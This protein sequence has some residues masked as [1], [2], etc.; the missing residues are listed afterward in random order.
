MPHIAIDTLQKHDDFVL[1]FFA[2][3]VASLLRDPT[4][5]QPAQVLWSSPQR[6]YVEYLTNKQLVPGGEGN[7]RFRLP[8]ISVQRMGSAFVSDRGEFNQ[9]RKICLD[10]NNKWVGSDFPTPVD[11][12]YQ[13][14]FLTYL[15]WQMN[16]WE[17]K[18]LLLFGSRQAPRLEK[19]TIGSFWK[20]K[21]IRMYVDGVD[22][23]SEIEPGTP[24][25]RTLRRTITLRIQSFIYPELEANPYKD[26][27]ADLFFRTGRVQ[28]IT[29]DFCNWEGTELWDSLTIP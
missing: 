16:W 24:D 12:T 1:D 4:T 3:N 5:D 11:L 18:S 23:N 8:R 6:R 9:I 21:W 29:I 2:A 25:D 7:D 27:D 26:H 15:Q 20:D 10:D 28:R 17:R 13:I 14:D 22:D 19:I